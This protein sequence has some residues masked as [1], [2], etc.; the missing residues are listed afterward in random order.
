MRHLPISLLLLV[1]TGVPL[2]AGA[3]VYKWTDANGTVH[4][5]DEPPANGAAYKNV[6]TAT[7]TASEA[8]QDKTSRSDRHHADKAPSGKTDDSQASSRVQDTPENREKLCDNLT[9]NLE[10]LESDSPVVTRDGDGGDKVL[11]GDS[12]KQE[13]ANARQQYQQYCQ[14]QEASD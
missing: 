5:A 4:Y 7:H 14:D 13:L 12:R 1:L 8:G 9:S 2:V 10:L 11:S 6:K 3:Q